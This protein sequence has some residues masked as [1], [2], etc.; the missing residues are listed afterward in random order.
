M[1]LKEII[2]LIL[3]LFLFL[4]LT[5]LAGEYDMVVV[6]LI[7]TLDVFGIC[8]YLPILKQGVAPKSL[9]LKYIFS[10][11]FILFLISTI[12][13]YQELRSDPP[14]DATVEKAGF[15]FTFYNAGGVK[16]L[17]L[18]TYT[19]PQKII[20]GIDNSKYFLLDYL[21][22]LIIAIISY[23]LIPK[24]WLHKNLVRIFYGIASILILII[25]FRYV[26]YSSF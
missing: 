19:F 20:M 11:T 4:F 18:R 9:V 21:Y 5:V 14:F 23:I 17:V 15:P 22:C 12:L 10:V 8:Y 25:L 7:F 1:K 16:S 13:S 26:F 2:I 6:P 3:L 24:K